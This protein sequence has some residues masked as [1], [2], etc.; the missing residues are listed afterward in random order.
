MTNTWRQASA[1]GDEEP[2]TRKQA[3][4]NT[5]SMPTLGQWKIKSRDQKF[6]DSNI[7]NAFMSDFHAEVQEA[8]PVNYIS[9]AVPSKH[10]QVTAR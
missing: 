9:T 10:G 6:C 5:V 1:Q 8:Q 2:C 4:P 3:P 7:T